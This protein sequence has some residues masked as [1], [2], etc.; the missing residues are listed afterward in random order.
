[1]GTGSTF[2]TSTDDDWQL[3]SNAGP[4]GQYSVSV[5]APGFKEAVKSGIRV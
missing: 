3:C 1:M 4:G 2:K 5:T